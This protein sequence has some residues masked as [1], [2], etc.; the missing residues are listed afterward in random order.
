MAKLAIRITLV[1]LVGGFLGTAMVRFAPGSGIDLE[2]LNTALSAESHAALRAADGNN[3]GLATFY[4]GYWKR[5]LHGD[6][7]ISVS[8]AEPVGRLLLERAPETIR[9]I[10]AGLVLAWSLGLG[11]GL[12]S[13]LPSTR[14]VAWGAWLL[15]GLL[16][17]LPAAV[18]ALACVLAKFPGRLAIGLI[19]FP[20]VYQFS[21]TLLVRSASMPHVLN[22]RAKGLGDWQV[23]LRHILPVVAPQI[24]ALGGVS[25]CMALAACIPVEAVC[26]MPG[27]G[28]LAWKAA[29]SRDLTLL[30]NLT[31]IVTVVTLVANSG[32]DLLAD[33]IGERRP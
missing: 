27:I 25:V 29:L 1:L 15:A 2:D 5:L 6:L 21:R 16:L 32:M 7:G 30:V 8:L 28:Q 18:L 24:L 13:L 14:L 10:G 11:L 3:V 20:K 12:L 33:L 9:S 31:M 22:A 4:A 19:V 26:D 23:L 17:C